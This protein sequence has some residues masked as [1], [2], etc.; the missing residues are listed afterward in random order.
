METLTLTENWASDS[1]SDFDA[2]EE[3]VRTTKE[4]FEDD[5]IQY[6]IESHDVDYY[7]HD[8]LQPPI[9]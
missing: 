6:D 2:M 4:Y 1:E 5:G 8:S 7:L 9:N 3:Q